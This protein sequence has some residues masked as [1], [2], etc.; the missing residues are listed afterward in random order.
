MGGTPSDQVATVLAYDDARGRPP[1]NASHSGYQRMSC[2]KTLV[3]VDAGPSPPTAVSGAAH[4]GC[5]SFEMSHGLER[6]IVNCGVPAFFHPN[7]RRVARSTAAHSTLVLND[8][9]SCRFMSGDRYRDTLGTPILSGPTRVNVK[10]SEDGQGILIT[11]RHDGYFKTIG[12]A[13]ERVL[14]LTPDG[15]RLAGV[16]RLIPARMKRSMARDSVAIRFHLHPNI[17][18]SRA[19]GGG[20]AMLITASDAAW[21]FTA[22]GADL[23]LEESIYFSD[24]HG[25]RRTTQIVLYT[26][27]QP[28]MEVNWQISRSDDG[29]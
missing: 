6:I 8:T 14:G 18:A 19:R 17:R 1:D 27:V 5:L 2:E 29:P 16:D 24:V 25:H 20:A 28:N 3:L 23:E 13:H 15:R 7:W 12:Y 4:A 26:R 10:R 21:E 11:A 9:S 22:S